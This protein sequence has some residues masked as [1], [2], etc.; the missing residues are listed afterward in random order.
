MQG[1]E[2]AESDLSK[3]K[4]KKSHEEVGALSSTVLTFTRFCSLTP[5]HFVDHS[6]PTIF[7]YFSHSS[8]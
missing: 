4:E 1:I 8:W 6:Y 5:G 3:E 2:A 7:T